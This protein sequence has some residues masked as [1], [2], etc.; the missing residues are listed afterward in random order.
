MESLV[1]SEADFCFWCATSSGRK[2]V[3][4]L[5]GSEADL[6]VQCE[7]SSGH[8]SVGFLVRSEADPHFR[9]PMVVS[10]GHTVDPR[11]GLGLLFD[12][13]QELW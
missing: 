10:L 7:T 6:H 9:L 2:S 3:G 5:V 1:R 12:Q 11:S 13:A 8:M 4:S